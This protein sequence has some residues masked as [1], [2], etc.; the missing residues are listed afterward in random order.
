MT[1]STGRANRD[2]TTR[3]AIDPPAFAPPPKMR[4][5]YLEARKSEL[6]AL[7]FQAGGND[8]KPVMLVIN[9]VRG[10]GAMYGFGAV[11]SAAEEVFRAVQ[12]GDA[13]SLELL[14]AYAE[15][16]RGASV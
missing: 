11:G 9:H 4:R 16:V 7:L 15:A 8:W 12:G 2:S 6:D 14:Q 1:H 10:S 3:I 13:K 5:E